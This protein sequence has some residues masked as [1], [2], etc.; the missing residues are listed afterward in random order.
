MVADAK[1]TGTWEKALA[2]IEG[3]T[4]DPESFML[5]IREYTGKVTG[6]ILRLKF[7]SRRHAP[8][9]PQVQDRQCDSEGKS[10]QVRP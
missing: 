1:L 6:E 4:L 9:L 5:S 3:H 8:Y 2:Q 10:R 7:P